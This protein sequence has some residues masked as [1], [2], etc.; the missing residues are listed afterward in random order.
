LPADGGPCPACRPRP[1][2]AARPKAPAQSVPAAEPDEDAP[3]KP[4]KARKP[5]P[6]PRKPANPYR[7]WLLFVQGLYIPFLGGVILL[8][9]AVAALLL[10][11]ASGFGL[12]AALGLLVGFTVLHLLVGAASVFRRVD[13]KD[14]LE[15]ELPPAWQEGLAAMVGRVA[16]ARGLRPPD[17]IRMHAAT[18]AHVYQ[19]AKRQTVLVVGGMAVAALSQRA[20]AG[21]VAHEL[22]HITNGDTAVSARAARW[23]GV[24]ARLDVL[25]LTKNWV[26]WNPLGWAFRGYHHLYYRLWFAY[27]RACEYEADYHEAL[28]AG[29]D[30]AAGALVLMTVLGETEWASLG[31]VAEAAVE[32]DQKL[33][34]IF[35]EQVRRVRGAGVADWEEAMRKALRRRSHWTDTHPSLAD[36]L[37]FLGVKPK[38]ALRLAAD[39]GGEPAAALFANWPVVERFLTKTIMN[40]VRENV[41][42]RQE[43]EELI[44]AL[45][46]AG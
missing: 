8:G 14:P 36:R 27:Q 9:L 3:T 38:K 41:R 5:K 21:V 20:L 16:A 4:A 37:G 7:G 45:T 22:A 6:P 43:V 46:R 34:H 44:D 10:A 35:A 17:A 1:P 40:I 12:R 26:R 28:Q 15:F 29:V 23:H 39:L 42:A 31:G 11:G 32:M 18:V 24:M 25:F 30:E 19:D 2:A 13:S 33:D